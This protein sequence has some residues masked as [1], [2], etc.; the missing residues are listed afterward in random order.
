MLK[1]WKYMIF[2]IL[3]C[4]FVWIASSIANARRFERQ[5]EKI[6]LG[7]SVTTAT[8]L[9]RGYLVRE[10]LYEDARIFYFSRGFL[11]DDSHTEIPISVKRAVHFPY[12][13]GSVQVL[14]GRDQKV[15]AYAWNGESDQIRTVL[16]NFQ[17]SSFS[18]L[19]DDVLKSLCHAPI[20]VNGNKAD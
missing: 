6:E 14:V 11:F 15:R 20:L 16:G 12:A 17:G 19:G 5:Y 10:C 8:D 4:A 3:L 18:I 7:S 9:F 2:I 13:Y 1:N